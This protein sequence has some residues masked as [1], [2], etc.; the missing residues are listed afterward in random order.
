MKSNLA[1]AGEHSADCADTYC[2]LF[3]PVS[4]PTMVGEPGCTD[5]ITDWG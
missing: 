2:G 1:L 5:N 4:L 3:K